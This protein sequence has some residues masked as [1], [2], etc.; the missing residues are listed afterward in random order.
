MQ[1]ASVDLSPETREF[2]VRTLRRLED[3]GVPFLVGGAYALAILAGIVRHTKDLDVFVR[4][5]DRDRTLGALAEAGYRTEVTFP[6]WLA[7]AHDS[8]GHL[9]DV[10]YSSGNAEARVDSEWFEHAIPG[11]VFGVSV[12]L[13]PA[14]EMLWSKA[15]VM[16]R[17]RF[18]GADM[19][20]LLRSR[21]HDL[22][23]PRLLRRFGPHGRLLLCYLLLFGYIYPSERHHVP[24]WVLRELVGHV[25]AEIEGPAPSKRV[26]Y[27]T[28]I[29]REQFLVDIQHWGYADARREP[30]GHMTADDVALWTDAIWTK[31]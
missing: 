18:D 17:E 7:K 3:S 6:H 25:Q 30:R 31:K 1:A 24:A 11:E 27:G 4:P 13:C 2:Y 21:A 9:V 10:I 20:H 23:W 14:E 15:F 22:D 16:E 28:L 26:C 5:E 29:S 19:A 12:R 8:S